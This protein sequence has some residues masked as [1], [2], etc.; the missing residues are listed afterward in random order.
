MSQLINIIKAVTFISLSSVS[1]LASSNDY[2]SSQG[3]AG[4]NRSIDQIDAYPETN[5]LTK[6]E[7]EQRRAARMHKR[8]QNVL[9]NE[10]RQEARRFEKVQIKQM[11]AKIRSERKSRRQYE[12]NARKELRKMER[13]MKSAPNQQIGAVHFLSQD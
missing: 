1:T 13:E 7:R 3:S 12:R 9:S 4:D 8:Q 11:N 2:E 6:E 10:A 5:R